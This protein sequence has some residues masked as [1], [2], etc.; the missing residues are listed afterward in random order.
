M[1]DE[2]LNSAEFSLVANCLEDS[3]YFDEAGIQTKHLLDPRL[4]L[5]WNAISRVHTAHEEVNCLT[6]GNTLE[7]AGKLE[8]LGGL[9][10]LTGLV[11]DHR[12]YVPAVNSSAII[13]EAWT[14]R[15]LLSLYSDIKVKLDNGHSTAHVLTDL[16]S[17]LNR[18][19]EQSG[20]QLPTLAETHNR[21]VS[22]I[23]ADLS[24]IE[25][26]EQIHFGLETGLGIERVVPGGLPL[27]KVVALYGESGNFKTTLKNNLAWGVG[28]SGAGRVIDFSFEDDDELTTQRFLGYHSGVSYGH[29][30][31]RKLDS[32]SRLRVTSLSD[33]A[34]DIA[35]NVFLAGEVPPDIDEIIR[36][37][38]HY[39]RQHN[40]VCVILDYIQLISSDKNEL[41]RAMRLL[42]LSA[43]REGICYV[44]VSQVKQ[45]VDF[46]ASKGEDA[47]P[48]I[49][50]MLGSSSF[51]TAPKLTLGVYRPYRYHKVPQNSS[52]LRVP[53]YTKLYNEHVNGENI[54]KSIIEV[55][56]QKNVLGEPEVCLPLMVDMT[57]G[58]MECLEQ[59]VLDYIQ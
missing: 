8:Q 54:Y 16:E 57:T 46:R 14:K 5:V 3:K 40:V 56:V 35:Q 53:N 18:L 4:R 42:Q 43:K 1:T 12:D 37:S 13:R 47:R 23:E 10:Y 49:T 11:V 38:R 59:S 29:I 45:D 44:V 25:A 55:W 50:D 34:L 7:K 28:K 24:R 36:I 58:R 19:E 17:R 33:E 20:R 2:T 22:R 32:N 52:R 6:V 30:A 26:G 39:R 31:T 48:R 27:G 51:R 9:S 21:E 15:E 41:D